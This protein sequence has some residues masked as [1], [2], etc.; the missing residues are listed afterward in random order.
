MQAEAPAVFDIS[1]EPAET[2]ELY[3]LGV[4]PTDDYGRRCLLARRLVEHGVTFVTVN[5]GGW[6]MHDNIAAVVKQ[7]AY[8]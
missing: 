3:G 6:D 7:P 2:R 4:E 1:R 8:C 5:M